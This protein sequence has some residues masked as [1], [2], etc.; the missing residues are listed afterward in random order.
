MEQEQSEKMLSDLDIA[1]TVANIDIMVADSR[2]K[3]FAKQISEQIEESAKIRGTGIARRSVAYLQEKIYASMAI[4]AVDQINNKPAGFIYIES[5]ETKQYVANSGLIVFPD[6][7][8]LG[9]ARKIKEAA[10]KLSRQ[11]FPNAKLFGLTTN[12]GVMKINSSLGYVPVN[13]QKLT[14]DPEFWDGCQSCVNYEIL[15]SKNR[16]QCI[17]TAMLYDPGTNNSDSHQPRKKKVLLAFSGGLDTSYCVQYLINKQDCEVH[18]VTVNTGGFSKEELITIERQAK[19]LGASSHDNIDATSRFYTECIKYLIYGNVLKNNTYPLCVSAERAFQS[20]MIARKA[21]ELQ[22]DAIAHGSTGA[23]NDQVRFDLMFEILCPHM[24]IITP[25][26]DQKLTRSQEQ[27]YLHQCNVSCSDSQSKYSINQG[28]WGTSVGGCETLTAHLAL[29]EEA[30]PTPM[31]K[32]PDET[33]TIKLTFYQGEPIAINDEASNAVNLIQ[34]LQKMAQPYGVGRDIHIGDT[35]VNIKGRVGFEAAAPI[36]M[37]KAHHTLEKHTLTRAQLKIK[38]QIARQYGEFIHDGQF[39]EPALRDM[40]TFLQSTQA[41]V[42][43][44]VYVQLAPW[45]MQVVGCQS[46]YDLMTADQSDYGEMNQNW[47][48]RDVQGLTRILSNQIKT[49]YQLSAE[50]ENLY[51]G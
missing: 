34:K 20:Y 32:Q 35:L 49:H 29:P 30:W 47:D 3:H 9:L 8:N 13:Y 17:C 16:K 19:S 4:I 22:V 23:G 6:Y 2:H 25:V 14:T 24:E 48:A 15:Q 33:E 5:W 12:T 39:L 26:R 31:T 28:L 37:I 45:Y 40:E 38:D 44:D 18:T 21:R 51:A 42:S 27:A 1:T 10:F 43:G 46:S 41:R 50:Y 36:I 11:K 7:R